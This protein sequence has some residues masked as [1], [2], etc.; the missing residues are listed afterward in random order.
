MRSLKWWDI[1]QIEI[2]FIILL[3][4][5]LVIFVLLNQHLVILLIL[6]II[7]TSHLRHLLDLFHLRGFA[8]VLLLCNR[9]F[10]L[11][12]EISQF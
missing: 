1:V 2:K 8:V 6:V 12:F 4:N 11:N 3:H 9:R 10:L 7:T 5:L